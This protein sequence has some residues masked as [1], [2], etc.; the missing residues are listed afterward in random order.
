MLN[1]ENIL[2]TT[3]AS[4]KMEGMDLCAGDLSRIKDCLEGKKDFSNA[5]A[6]LV[7]SYSS[8]VRV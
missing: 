5:I 2:K 7:K 8:P 1:V 3:D 6:E 4:M